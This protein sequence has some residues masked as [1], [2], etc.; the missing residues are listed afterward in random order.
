MTR[1]RGPWAVGWYICLVLIAQA[2]APAANQPAATSTAA[3]PGVSPTAVTVEPAKLRIVNQPF[4]SFAPYHIG[5]AEG[6]FAEQGIDAELVS[7]V[8]TQEIIPALLAGEVDV[9]AGLMSAGI[10]NTVARGGSLMVVADKGYIDPAGCANLALLARGTLF[11]ETDPASAEGMR[12]KT[13]NVVAATWNE[14]YLDRLLASVGLQ[15]GDVVKTNI[16]TPS[17]PEALTQD[18]LD[19]TVQNEPWVLRMEQM[20]HRRVLA[21]VNEL[22]PDSQ[23]AVMYFGPRLLGENAV[24][25]ERFMVAYLKAVR[26]YNEGKTE[27]N[28]EILA[29]AN[30]LDTDTLRV[31]C[32]PGLKSDGLANTAS[33]L[34]FQEW[35]LN[36]G[37]VTQALSLDQFWNPHFAEYASQALDR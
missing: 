1:S 23:A 37:H 29:A 16:P 8:Q 24:V 15:P 4:I 5:V 10:L 21:P 14:Y 25:G 20:G 36:A 31:M 22:L 13:V 26:Q 9:A 18:A 11:D 28:I 12:G 34:D 3:A 2:C 17:Q 19:Y 33:M 35:A 30:N 7:L 6:Y 32:W 27:R